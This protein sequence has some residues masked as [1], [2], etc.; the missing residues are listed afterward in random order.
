MSIRNGFGVVKGLVSAN[1]PKM[2]V[3]FNNNQRLHITTITASFTLE[4]G[5][6]APTSFDGALCQ[7]V[8]R[9][10]SANVPNT[11]DSGQV[12]NWAISTS[13]ST[14]QSVCLWEARFNNQFQHW[15]F[16]DR[17]LVL[18]PKEDYAV[19]LGAPSVDS[20]PLPP[21]IGD[22]FV[23]VLSV[24]GWVEDKENPFKTLRTIQ[25]I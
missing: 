5:S 13:E 10:I 17:G 2:V 21:G 1:N 18:D 22:M 11:P 4:A 8:K 16:G 19:I 25:N 14:P 7:L 23:A 6:T 12:E 3:G 20:T 24:N 15:Y 9:K